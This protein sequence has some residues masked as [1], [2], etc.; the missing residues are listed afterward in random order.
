MMTSH[1]DSTG[2]FESPEPDVTP[3]DITVVVMVTSWRRS[4]LLRQQKQTMQR[5]K[6]WKC[7][8]VNVWHHFLFSRLTSSSKH[9]NTNTCVS[10]KKTKKQKTNECNFSH[11]WASS[12]NVNVSL[13][14][15]LLELA[16]D[17]LIPLMTRVPPTADSRSVTLLISV[18]RPQEDCVCVD[19]WHPVVS[20]AT[21]SSSVFVVLAR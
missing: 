17:W 13:E 9:L 18:Y 11:N 6:W 16:C 2:V 19:R 21:Q 4:S 20:V 1:Y 7:E 14:R 5:V 8:R 3:A 12:N 15:L 10:A